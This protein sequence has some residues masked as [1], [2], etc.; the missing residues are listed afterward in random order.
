LAIPIHKFYFWPEK[1]VSARKLK[2]V[3]PVRLDAADLFGL[4]LVDEVLG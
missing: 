3:K 1:M 4:G 2:E